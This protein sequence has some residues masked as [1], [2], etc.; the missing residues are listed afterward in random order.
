MVQVN[1]GPAS[2]GRRGK[3]NAGRL[4]VAVLAVLLYL[5]GGAG[6]GFY[7]F[8]RDA[9]QRQAGVEEDVPKPPEPPKSARAAP[10]VSAAEQQK[11]DDTIVKAVWYLRKNVTQDGSWGSRLPGGENPVTLGLTA[12]PALTLLECGI[13]PKDQ[14]IQKAAELVRKQAWLF[15]AVYDNYQR[16]LVLL[17]LDRLGD[18]RDE[19]L[20]QYLALCLLAGQQTDP[21]R[22]KGYLG[23]WGYYCPVLDRGLAKTLLARLSDY[24]LSAADWQKAARKGQEWVQKTDNSNTQFAILALWVARRHGVNVDKAMAL[25]DKRFRDTQ[26]PAGNDPE[27]NVLD[28]DGGWYYREEGNDHGWVS[29]NKWPTMTC[30]GLLGLAVAQGVR[31]D[32]ERKDVLE[33]A[34]VKRALGMLGREIDRQ[35]EH[36]PTDLYFLW[37]L[38]R[39]AVVFDLEKIGG[40]D[41]YA[42]GY[43]TLVSSQQED[44]SWA[45][46]LYY[47]FNPICNTCFALLFLERANLAQDLSTKLQLLAEKK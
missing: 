33:E 25:V 19:E 47:D 31:D 42:W 22:G 34:A 8:T 9:G 14:L 7:C 41:W 12:L 6:L 44:G 27:R 21:A 16:A 15:Q 1:N 43:K 17:F 28:L 40:K 38:E 5:L 13:S 3:L 37:S 46:G 39:V 18:P 32:K 24:N 36:R 10:Q 30:T 26:F 45:G 35:G 23:G 11:I 2:G 4:G 29:G 20:I